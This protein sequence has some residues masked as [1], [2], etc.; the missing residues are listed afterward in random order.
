[1]QGYT[2]AACRPDQ[3]ISPTKIK[4]NSAE[5]VLIIT[6]FLLQNTRGGIERTADNVFLCEA[7]PP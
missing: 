2:R 7:Q 5:I 4:I 6:P 1:M 3:G